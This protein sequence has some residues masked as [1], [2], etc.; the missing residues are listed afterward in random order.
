ALNRY[1]EAHKATLFEA[2]HTLEIVKGAQVQQL[3]ELARKMPWPSVGNWL[4]DHAGGDASI[5]I[6][7][8]IIVALV[9]KWHAARTRGGYEPRAVGLNTEAAHAGAIRVPA[10]VTKALLVSGGLAGLASVPFVLGSKHYFEQ[11]MLA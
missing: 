6:S 3:D 1:R 4:A 10:V 8:A 2:V 9:A 7:F 5:A 11:G